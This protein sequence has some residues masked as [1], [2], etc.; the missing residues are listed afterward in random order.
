MG[1][2]DLDVNNDRRQD[3]IH[4]IKMYSQCEKLTCLL[5]PHFDVR[6]EILK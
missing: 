4:K 3:C 1:F 6:C 5:V 2:V